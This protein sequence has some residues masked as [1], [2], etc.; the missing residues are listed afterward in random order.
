MGLGVNL[1]VRK[2]G[3]HSEDALEKSG[4][5]QQQRDRCPRWA[6]EVQRNL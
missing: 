6:W 2:E 3:A 1:E 4:S 5:E